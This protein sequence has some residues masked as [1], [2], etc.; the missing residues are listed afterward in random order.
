MDAVERRGLGD[1]AGIEEAAAVPVRD[2]AIEA[3]KLSRFGNA[4]G[5]H[6]GEIGVGRL[7]ERRWRDDQHLRRLGGKCVGVMAHDLDQPL[8]PLLAAERVA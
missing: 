2:L 8:D 7:A 6:R 1:C 3:R 4:T 5:E